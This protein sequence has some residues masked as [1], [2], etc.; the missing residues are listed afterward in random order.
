MNFRP[1]ADVDATSGLIDDEQPGLSG[2]PFCDHDLLLISTGKVA[3]E[4]PDS[5]GF[6][7]QTGDVFLG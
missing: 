7:A 4:L 1:G 2:Q 6:D 3:S 5:W